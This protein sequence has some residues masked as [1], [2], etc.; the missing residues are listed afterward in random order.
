M[1]EVKRYHFIGI[2]G[3]GM[4][5]IARVLIAM[6]QQVSGSDLKESRNTMRLCELGAEIFIGHSSQSVNGAEIVVV[7]SAIPDS[8][9]ELRAAQERNVPV[10]VRAEMLAQLA[11]GKLAIAVAG[12]HGK[13][14]TT[15]MISLLLEQNNLDPTFLIGGE[16][17]DIGSNAKYGRGKYFVAEADE[18]DGSFLFLEPKI[19]VITNIEADHLDYYGSYDRIEETFRRFTRRLSEDGLAIVC[20]DFDNIKKVVT[21]A[22]RRYTTYGTSRDSDLT[23]EDIN[24]TSFGSSFTVSGKGRKLG[25]VVLR[26]PGMHNVYNALAA[27]SLGLHLE[28]SFGNIAAALERFGG[29]QRR[30]QLMGSCDG[31][32]LIDDYAHHPTEVRVTLEAARVGDWNRI[33]GVFQPHRYSR[34]KYL[35]REFAH[36][37]DNAD[38]I[39]LTD[40]Y[41]A[42]E[43]PVPGVTGKLL[44]DA[45]LQG[46]SHKQV[47]Y[48]PKKSDIR[49]FLLTSAKPGD[50]ILTMGAGD[51]W[52]AGE[53]FLEILRQKVGTLSRIRGEVDAFSQSGM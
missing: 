28:I 43:E 38:V 23:A 24:L 47:V 35:H 33:I 27:V 9:C 42:G 53:E 40:I 11:R 2:G 8:N 36:A 46:N 48:L 5:G 52:T 3:A 12:T 49:D 29:V 51:I 44:V 1:K 16:L 19:V 6:G 39:V 18:S 25:K 32:T 31:I 37:F 34:T 15:S 22:G 30:F 26:V 45:V 7:S 41:G 10:L 20:G 13:T 4:S 50:L 21:D 17:N 14:T